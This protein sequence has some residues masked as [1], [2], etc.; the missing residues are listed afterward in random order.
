M[1]AVSVVVPTRGRARFLPL[2]LDAAL[3][4]RDADIEVVVVEDGTEPDRTSWLSDIEDPR[5]RLVRH[6]RPRGV[7]AARN[8]GISSGDGEWVAFLDDDDLWAPEK[9]SR[10]LSAARSSGRK[11]VYSG[12]VAI[13]V[14]NRVL[15]VEHV[16]DA[17]GLLQRLPW[18][19]AV[20]TS[21]V[22]VHREALREAGPFDIGLRLTEDWDMYLRLARMGPPAFVPEHLVAFRTHPEQSSLD[23]SGLLAE[24]DRFERRHGV[25]TD[26][27]A[28]IRGAAWS[29]LQAGRR[30]AALGLYRQAIVHG[31]PSSAARAAVALLPRPIRDRILGR[32]A[33]GRGDDLRDDQR[34]VDAVVRASS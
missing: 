21:N 22:L 1:P 30:R 7:S 26:R 2:A 15:H 20:P 12:A 23:A 17:D 10:Q 11:W 18:S 28:I 9:L 3:R 4:Q 32:T 25:R 6:D 24:L 27:V 8:T 13:D 16:L 5:L 31:D 14:R 29:S 33:T 34:W 19:N